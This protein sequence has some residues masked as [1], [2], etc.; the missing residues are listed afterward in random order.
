MKKY[1]L[2]DLKDFLDTLTE[3]QLQQ[4]ILLADEDDPVRNIYPSISEDDLYYNSDEPGD[5][6]TLAELKDIWGND[7]HQEEY[8]ISFP[9]GTV[10][11]YEDF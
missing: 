9:K 2:D 6:G 8:T 7:F 1:T 11:F 10:L 5:C 3:D 4:P